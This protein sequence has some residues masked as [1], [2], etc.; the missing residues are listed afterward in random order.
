MQ[1]KRWFSET[2]WERTCPKFEHPWPTSLCPWTPFPLWRNPT[3]FL[4]KN[5]SFQLGE[6]E[7]GGLLGL[8]S[9]C[10]CL[11][12]LLLR[13]KDNALCCV[14]WISCGLR[15]R[16]NYVAKDI[17]FGFLAWALC[18]MLKGVVELAVAVKVT[19]GPDS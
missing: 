12:V 17:K 4:K 18:L 11:M 9:V 2:I 8:E 19:M 6:R 3:P 13:E 16:R 15:R 5:A 14:I 1:T 10:A 7:R